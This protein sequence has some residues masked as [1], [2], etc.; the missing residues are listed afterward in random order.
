MIFDKDDN[1]ARFDR[2]LFYKMKSVKSFE[3]VHNNC[4][5][6]IHTFHYRF[7]FVL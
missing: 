2:A 6:T 7:S 1:K 5:I 3:T 4:H